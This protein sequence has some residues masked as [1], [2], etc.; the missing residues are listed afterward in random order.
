[1]SVFLVNIM[2]KPRLSLILSCAIT[3]LFLA[4][5]AISKNRIHGIGSPML[6]PVLAGIGEE[7]SQKYEIPSPFMEIGPTGFSFQ[8]F[9]SGSDDKYPDFVSS[10]RLITENEVNICK[11][12]NV[13]YTKINFMYDAI[14]LITTKS[15]GRIES[16]TADELFKIISGYVFDNNGYLKKNDTKKWSDINPKFPNQSIRFYGTILTSGTYDFLKEK[17]LSPRC[18]YA[19]DD[20]P[21][22]KYCGLARVDGHYI[23]VPGG[24]TLNIEKLSSHPLSVAMIPYLNFT[25][26]YHRFAPISYEGMVPND[27]NISKYPMS[28]ILYIYYKNSSLKD[29]KNFDLFIDVVKNRSVGDS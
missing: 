4:P 18:K 10:S 5:L 16:L 11:K 17:V 7:M 29:T 24:Y 25:K 26:Q 1:M 19:K 12:N 27:A 3:S 2:N 22:K 23:P 21:L 8:F 9:C 20:D 14:A 6:F 28:R 13:E 15:Q